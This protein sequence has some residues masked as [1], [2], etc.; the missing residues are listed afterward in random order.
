MSPPQPTARAGAPAPPARSALQRLHAG[1]GRVLEAVVI[2]LMVALSV[3]VV[4]GVLFRAMG[5]SLAWYDE[6]ASVL[7]AWLTYYGAALAALKGAHIGF[8]GLV[9]SLSTPWRIAAVVFAEAC[10]L[11]FFMLLA[12]VGVGVL[13]VL[14]TDTLVSLPHISVAWVQ[15]VIPVSAVLIVLAELLNL[16]RLLAEARGRV[17]SASGVE[18][19]TSH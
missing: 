6:I 18:T 3:E 7:L 5:R 16:P 10:V 9:K 1:Y 19:E 11:G 12:W 8:P 15:S 13:D 17:V 4:A 14:A 2:L